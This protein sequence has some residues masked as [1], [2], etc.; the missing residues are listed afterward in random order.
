MTLYVSL[1][2]RSLGVLLTVLS[3]CLH[4]HIQRRGGA[5]GEPQDSERLAK[6]A[7]LD[8][9]PHTYSYPHCGGIWDHTETE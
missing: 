3:L 6:G 5:R 4:D 9:M 2:T 8:S 1:H 7:G